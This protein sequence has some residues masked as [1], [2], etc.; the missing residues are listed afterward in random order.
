MIDSN[1]VSAAKE[2]LYGYL[3]SETFVQGDRNLFL[4]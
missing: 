2:K 3:F 1:H 4:I